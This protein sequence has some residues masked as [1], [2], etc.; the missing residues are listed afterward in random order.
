M[1]AF[2]FLDNVCCLDKE[3]KMFL[4]L[5]LALSLVK[6][7]ISLFEGALGKGSSYYLAPNQTIV[8]TKSQSPF[9][10]ETA[11]TKRQLKRRF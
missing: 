6:R 8:G 11:K 9:R 1:E 10:M 5:V 7:K 2:F 3:D 4:S